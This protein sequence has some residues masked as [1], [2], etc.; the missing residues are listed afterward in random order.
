VRPP[1]APDWVTDDYTADAYRRG[2]RLQSGQWTNP[3]SI[4][5]GRQSDYERTRTAIDQALAD[6]RATGDQEDYDRVRRETDQMWETQSAG[7]FVNS[8]SGDMPLTEQQRRGA[9]NEALDYLGRG[10]PRLSWVNGLVQGYADPPSVTKKAEY[11]GYL[12]YI[13]AAR[14]HFGLWKPEE[15]RYGRPP[16]RQWTLA[17]L[18]A[19]EQKARDL[20]GSNEARA[21][22][23][24]QSLPN[25]Q[26][27]HFQNPNNFLSYNRA[28]EAAK[29]LSSQ[30]GPQSPQGAVAGRITT[31]SFSKL[32][33]T[34]QEDNTPGPKPLE[35]PQL[36]PQT[37]RKGLIR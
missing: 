12:K 26:Q 17:D 28:V 8:A 16:S 27:K 37:T 5:P 3:L 2:W 21:Y 24:F 25:D 15:Q 23:D 13:A 30:P 35:Y 18:D 11:E 10:D 32:Q 9:L 1:G 7:M 34:P 6:A 31:P 22:R 29:N 4:D 20:Y 33:T 19:L 14:Q 36:S